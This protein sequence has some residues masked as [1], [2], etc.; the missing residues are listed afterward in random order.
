MDELLEEELENDT[1]PVA[2]LKPLIMVT[3][4]FIPATWSDK[5]CTALL[6][7]SRKPPYF[8]FPP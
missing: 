5:E 6:E 2:A 4:R 1:A 8:N 3:P 7:R